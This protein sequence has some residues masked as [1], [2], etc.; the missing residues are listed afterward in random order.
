M[1]LTVLVVVVVGGGGCV[2]VGDVGG[3]SS[4]VILLVYC[5][6]TTV[7]VD[8]IP[9]APIGFIAKNR[10][11]EETKPLIVSIISLNHNEKFNSIFLSYQEWRCRHQNNRRLILEN[12]FSENNEV[13]SNEIR[14][15]SVGVNSEF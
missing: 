2:V 8:G 5:C 1:T 10:I 6:W 13:R 4:K 11:L 14:N 9:F 7:N 3:V 12:P 15:V